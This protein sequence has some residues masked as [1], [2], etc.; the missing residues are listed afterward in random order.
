MKTKYFLGLATMVL[1][2][3]S[4]TNDEIVGSADNKTDIQEISFE[5]YANATRADVTATSLKTNG[6]AFG[7]KGY[8]TEAATFGGT[9][10]T[11]GAACMYDNTQIKFSGKTESTDGS[12]NYADASKT[13]F[14]PNVDVAFYAYYPY[15]ASV[16]SAEATTGTKYAATLPD[17][18]ADAVLTFDVDGTKDYLYAKTNQAKTTGA[19]VTIPFKHLYAKVKAINLKTTLDMKI[20]VSAVEVCKVA[21]TGRVSVTKAGNVVY[22]TGEAATGTR[23][24]SFSS[25]SEITVEKGEGKN[26]DLVTNDKDWYIFP[27]SDGNFWNG[28]HTT[29]QTGEAAAKFSIKLTAKIYAGSTLVHN[30]DVYIPVSQSSFAIAAGKRYVFNIDLVNGI[31]YDINGDALLTP[32]MFDTDV[33]DWVDGND[34][35]VNITI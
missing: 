25:G 19:T 22:P 32:I 24:L 31:G 12:W 35:T 20:V 4:C 33:T 28:T 3:A 5:S 27:V 21:H 17:N 6:N 29:G 7:V 9:S 23:T 15:A 14:W 2:V 10:H 13:A 18:D 30:G 8:V 34:V 16:A 1:A 11:A 26:K